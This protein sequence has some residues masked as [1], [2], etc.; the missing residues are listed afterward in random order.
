MFLPTEFSEV[1]H[2]EYKQS[3]APYARTVREGA[4]VVLRIELDDFTEDDVLFAITKDKLIILGTRSPA[5]FCLHLDIPS[6]ADARGIEAHIT[7]HVLIMEMPIH[8]RGP[9]GSSAGNP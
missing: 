1:L 5:S 3:F 4:K 6:D 8:A 7:D 2:L 9:E